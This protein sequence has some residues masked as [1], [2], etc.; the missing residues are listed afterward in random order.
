MPQL[1]LRP[2]SVAVELYTGQDATIK[3]VG[4][5]T[6]TYTA[7]QVKGVDQTVVGNPLSCVASG[8]DWIVTVPAALKLDHSRIQIRAG[9]ITVLELEPKWLTKG[10]PGPTTT[11]ITVAAGTT[12]TVQVTVVGGTVPSGPVGGV[13]AGNLPN[14]GFAVDMA[15]QAELNTEATTARAAEA[16]NAAAI[17]SEATARAAAD[18]AEA[19]ARASADTAEA[20][21]RANAVAA[22]ATARANADAL[23]IPLTQKA[24]VN[25]VASLDSG[26]LIPQS[27]L[28]SVALTEFLGAV[29]SQAAMLA[30][31]GQRGDWCSRTDRGTDWQLIAEPSSSLASW[32]EMTYPASPVS[33][34]NSRTGAVTGLAEQTALDAEATAR[35]AAD[36]AEASARATA[37]TTNANAIAAEATR[38]IA[39]EATKQP[40]GTY[41]SLVP[42]AVKTA[43]YTLVAGDMARF[44]TSGGA[45]VAT[46]PTAPAEPCVVG[47]KLTTAGNPLTFNCGGA[48]VINKAGGVTS[49]TLTYLNQAV[50]LQYKATGA[51]WVVI[52]DD[53]PKSVLDTLYVGLTGP[54]TVAGVK[55]FSSPPIVPDPVG[56]TDAANKQWALARI[57]DLVN[58]APGILDTLGEIAAAL[59]ADESTAAALATTVAG[60]V[61]LSTVTT[62]DDLIV[63]SGNAAVTRLGVAASRIIGKKA[64]GGLGALTPAEIVAI[65]SGSIAESDVA[66]LVADLAAKAPLG[67]GLGVLGKSGY[68]Y[69]NPVA[70][71]STGN[72]VANTDLLAVPLPVAKAITVDRIGVEVTSQ[73]EGR[74]VADGVLNSTTTVTSATAAFVAGDVGKLVVGTGIPAG[75]TIASRTNATTIVLSQA[76]TGTASGVSLTFSCVIRLGIYNDNGTGYPNTLLLDA[77]VVTGDTNAVKEITISQALPVGLYWLVAVAQGAPT[78]LPTVRISTAALTALIGGSSATN[79]VRGSTREYWAPAG[80]VG[81]LP[82]PFPA[83]AVNAGRGPIVVVRCV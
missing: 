32:R 23:L 39:A 61:P 43:N 22:E 11:T 9:A 34:V 24:A 83:A 64:T 82:S 54:Q 45:L 76:A 33:S 7:R 72:M 31:T 38:A 3:V 69:S 42:T 35:A 16:S 62:V 50:L 56:A 41:L 6:A 8:A 60:K 37:D 36:T 80:A 12:P 58:S 53:L 1:D 49:G 26:G 20:T 44:D 81:A 46:L 74:T 77:G 66:N 4:L 19:T 5:P 17:S 30:L 27:Q 52:A 73:G 14:P 48:D 47:L 18:T 79:A 65:L 10:A 70:V 51:V 55:T 40:V 71:A 15:T 57:A 78:T 29:G 63:A 59:Q 21:A 25:G 68:Y 2:R 28:P 13:L 75:T 67:G